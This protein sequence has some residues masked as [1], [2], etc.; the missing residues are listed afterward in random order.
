MYVHTYDV[1]TEGN[2]DGEYL[3][4]IAVIMKS[5]QGAELAAAGL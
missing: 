2:G 5:I 4:V 1:A 3:I